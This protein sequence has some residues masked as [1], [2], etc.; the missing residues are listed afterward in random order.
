METVIIMTLLGLQ[1]VLMLALIF[2]K[3]LY[4]SVLYLTISSVIVSL[5]YL[6]FN[7]PDIALA[8]I[9]VGCALIP[10]VYI[11]AIT[12]QKD[13]LVVDEVMDDYSREIIEEIRLFCRE[14]K[15]R[16]RLMYAGLENEFSLKEVF[17]GSNID[18]VISRPRESYRLISKE[19]S[20]VNDRLMARLKERKDPLRLEFMRTG[21]NVHED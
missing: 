20:S 19:S 9:A 5:L 11:I 18:M 16:L 2:Q 21:E 6:M 8:E 7:A 4:I 12:K 10:F 14:E 15:L 1:M 13:F 3:N 17:R